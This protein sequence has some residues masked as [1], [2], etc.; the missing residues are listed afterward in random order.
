MHIFMH[1]SK[2]QELHSV[3]PSSQKSKTNIALYQSAGNVVIEG[4]KRGTVCTARDWVLAILLQ[5]AYWSTLLRR[6]FRIIS[7][8][9]KK[10]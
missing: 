7:R 2:V 1:A 9:N 6:T 5:T 3:S 4:S 10:I 8:R